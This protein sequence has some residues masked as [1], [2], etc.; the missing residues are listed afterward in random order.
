MNFDLGE[1]WFINK[2][3][4]SKILN[5]KYKKDQPLIFAEV[6]SWK[7]RSAIWFI[8]NF[9]QHLDSVIYCIDT[10]NINEWND[11]NQEKVL[12]QSNSQ[13]A[14]ELDVENI[15][16]QFLFNINFKGYSNKCRVSKK[17]SIEALSD[18]NNNFFDFIYIDGDHS[19]QGC[20]D[21]LK[22]AWPKIKTG[23]I[24]FGDD[25]TWQDKGVF[26]VRK[27]VKKFAEENSLKTKPL[28]FHGN[29]YYFEK[30]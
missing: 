21:D 7:G 9:L 1:D 11:F 28:L 24:L 13:R 16:E 18:F 23:G 4:L 15:Y 6:G 25:W 5:K 17:R 10:W 19:E 27:A 14:K 29:G 2:K 30:K 22:A 8:E 3:L 12:L 26:P 20:Y